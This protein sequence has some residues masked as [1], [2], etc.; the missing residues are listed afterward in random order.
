M[1]RIGFGLCP[2]HGLVAGR[3]TGL[4]DVPPC[5]ARFR[6]DGLAHHVLY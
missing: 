2:N 1:G 6:L 5:L 4:D 3:T